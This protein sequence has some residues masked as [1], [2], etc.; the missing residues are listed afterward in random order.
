MKQYC[1]SKAE[2]NGLRLRILSIIRTANTDGLMFKRADM[3]SNG[4]GE[5]IFNSLL[6]TSFPTPIEI[7]KT[8]RSSSGLT[9]WLKEFVLEPEFL[10]V[11]TTK[12][13]LEP[14][15]PTLSLKTR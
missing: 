15:R 14:D 2:R 1:R 9:A 11:I 7:T 6:E 13:F 3:T 5:M 4:L 8:P 10:S 12:T